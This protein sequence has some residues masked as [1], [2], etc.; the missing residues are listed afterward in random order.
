[1]FDGPD[2]VV[3]L[4]AIRERPDDGHRWLALASW[5]WDHDRDDEAA[6]VQ[7]FWPNL[8]DCV[9]IEGHSVHATLRY[10]ARY[11]LI[12]GRRAREVE[13]RVAETPPTD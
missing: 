5:L 10:V 12:F 2:V 13:Q 6:A 4:N 1:M 3:I 9:L 8:R 7:V 11:A